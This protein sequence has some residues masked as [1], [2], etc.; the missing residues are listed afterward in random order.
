MA[1]DLLMRFGAF[2]YDKRKTRHDV[3]FNCNA[4]PK[5]CKTGVAKVV[6]KQKF[7]SPMTKSKL[8]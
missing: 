1:L 8:H 4:L 5:S 2:F 7:Q 3:Y 6:T